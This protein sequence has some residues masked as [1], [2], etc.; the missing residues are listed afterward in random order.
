M[1]EAGDGVNNLPRAVC[2]HFA[3][4]LNPANR[5]KARP[6]LIKAGG[7][8]GTH[9][10]PARFDPAV[11]F[12]NGLGAPEIGWITPPG[13]CSRNGGDHRRRG[14]YRRTPWRARIAVPAD[15]L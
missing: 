12:F 2:F 4:A 14:E 11:I 5:C 10:D 1:Q 9:R 3:A 15:W 7:E 6:F 8:F 13:G